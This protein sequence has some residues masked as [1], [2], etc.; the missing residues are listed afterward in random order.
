MED[1]GW[2]ATLAGGVAA[3]LGV[4]PVLHRFPSLRGARAAALSALAVSAAYVPFALGGRHGADVVAIHAAVYLV[5]AYLLGVVGS[6]REKTAGGRRSWFHWAPAAIVALLVPIIAA[7][8]V[9]VVVAERGLPEGLAGRLLPPPRG[10]DA[11]AARSVFPGVVPHDFQKKEA[12]YNRHLAQLER[13][14]AL[15][16]QVRKGW[17]GRAAARRASVFQVQVTDREGRPVTR[18]RVEGRF[19]RPSDSRLDQS[20]AMREVDP[21]LYRAT[22]TLPEP[23][24]WHLVLIIRRGEDR[25]ELRAATSVAAE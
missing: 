5:T 22:L 19:L 21:G 17:V 20:F 9:F 25:Y 15:G 16:W 8:V 3:I 11:P 23:G 4:F 18:A 24:I 10:G 6:H 2:L 13:Q 14:Q 1:L 12:L 7:N